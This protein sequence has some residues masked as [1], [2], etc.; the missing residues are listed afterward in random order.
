MS[1]AELMRSGGKVDDADE[2]H[3]DVDMSMSM[4]MHVHS[5]M[6]C[7]VHAYDDVESSSS[8]SSW[9]FIHS[10]AHHAQTI[11][12]VIGGKSETAHFAGR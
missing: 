6:V 3:Y 10:F 4:M 1:A 9:S 8:W 7:G 11:T 2:R 5:V 12:E